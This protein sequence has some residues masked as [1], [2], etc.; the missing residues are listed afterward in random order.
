[1]CDTSE[2]IAMKS[3]TF[4]AIARRNLLPAVTAGFILLVMVTALF[5]GLHTVS[6]FD[7]GWHLAT[8]RFVV[9]HHQI[10]RTDILSFT[11][12]GKPWA[13]PPFAGVLF[14]A[15][16]C[17]FGYAGLS[18]FTALACL[19]VIAYLVR[20]RDVASAILAM[21][22]LQSIAARTAPR[23]DLFSTVFFAFFL[24]ELWSYH[25]D[26]RARLWLLPVIMVFWV[27]LH[28]GFIAGLGI[29]A[30]YLLLELA[31][32]PF[33]VRRQRALLRLRKAWPWLA[34]TVAATLLNPWGA[35]IYSVARTLSGL[36]G[37]T[38]GKINSSSFIGEYQGVPLSLHLLKQLVDVRHLENG[39]TWLLL[40][41]ICLMGLAL[42]SKQLGAAVL[43]TVAL[44]AG[45][46]HARYMALFAITIATVGGTLLQGICAGNPSSEESSTAREP[47][48]S[49]PD[50]MAVLLLT[51]LCGLAAL[52]IADY[53]TSRTYVVFNSDWRFGAGE[54]VWFPERAAAFIER[55]QLPG[56]I[57]EEYALGGYAA[58]RLG[59]QYPDFLDGRS[60]RLNPGL[61]VEQRKL[62]SADPD[63][64]IWQANAERWNLNVVIVAVSGFR[65]LQKLNPL[66]FCRSTNWRPVYMDDVSMVFLR[67]VP[68]N[69]PWIDRLEIDCNTRELASPSGASR[70]QLYDFYFNSGA[71]LFNLHR[72]SQAE[73]SLRRASE[74]FPEDPNV[75]LILA[76]ICQRQQRF[77]AAEQEY[78]T[79]LQLNE[80]S[81]AW[82]SLGHLNAD[83]GRVAEAVQAIES[84]A[85]MSPQPLDMYLLLAQLELGQN[86]PEQALAM[87]RRAE[88]NS[89]YRDG[90]ESL[91]PELYA[92]I[93]EGRSEANRLLGHW[94]DA[95]EFQVEAVRLTPGSVGRWN[96][97]A[98]LYE[99]S[100]QTTLA[101]ETRRK[102]AEIQSQSSPK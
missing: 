42:W 80:N 20:R 16:Y 76:G 72:D 11:S 84:A 12:A 87:Y 71:L 36:S 62:Y 19:S 41:A 99:A 50:G 14:Y 30:A 70:A 60:D 67:N 95:I 53:A 8:G 59:P 2:Q 33:A 68:K 25:R 40:I 64:E 86:H 92:Q 29:V 102:A 73:Q 88:R 27:N 69:R 18:W 74:L 48:L 26:L 38:E 78:L 61:V 35:G 46:A 58:W 91:A 79:S 10:P 37:P 66:A 98:G 55:E 51:M 83:Q 81:G 23:A 43:L 90:G 4:G 17:V 13:Y 97:L 100:G 28:P 93:A 89:P 44:Y 54:S 101:A 5:A 49:I 75:H 15:V 57:F 32:F 3:L 96:R 21:L 34:A 77:R 94:P 7:M 6:D 39:F 24:G 47:L 45:L 85:R 22:A 9:Q 56:N 63:S 65:S 82:L 1:L 31:E 52:H